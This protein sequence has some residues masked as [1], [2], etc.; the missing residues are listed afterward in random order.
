M[1]IFKKQNHQ[2]LSVNEDPIDWTSTTS[3]LK[4]YKNPFDGKAI[5]LKSSK[6][7]NSKWYGM[8]PGKI[9]QVWKDES[10]RSINLGNFYHDREEAELLKNYTMQMH[11]KELPVIWPMYDHEGNKIAGSQRL[12]EGIYP[13]HLV[14]LKSAGLI[15]QS[16][17]VEIADGLLHISDY[18]TNKEI[19]FKSY[20]NWEGMSKKMLGVV[21][22]LDDCNYF[23][24]SLQL[25]LYMYMVL[26]HNPKLKPGKINIHH[27]TF[28]NTGFDQYG[29]P[30]A[31]L[32][33]DNNP[34]VKGVEYIPCDYLFSDVKA[35]VDEFTYELTQKRQAA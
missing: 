32:D 22:H 25:S 34:I 13:E 31:R 6:N 15:G 16:D 24:Y 11:G 5:A 28:E 27:V 21:S 23:H 8:D 10:N 1:I 7:Q 3:S 30:I 26:R 19:E 9:Q 2:Y 4:R 29:Y 14:F 33:Q 17:R 18:K 12:T 20:V 35:I